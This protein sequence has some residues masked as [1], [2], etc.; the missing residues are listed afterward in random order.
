M[1]TAAH[2]PQV[3]AC[4]RRAARYADDVVPALRRQC[5]CEPSAHVAQSG[6]NQRGTHAGSGPSLARL[7]DRSL[8]HRYGQQAPKRS[9]PSSH[10]SS[11]S[12]ACE[13]A[14][15]SYWPAGR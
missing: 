5:A 13:C 1:A 2:A 11:G 8:P 10:W 14:R 9:Y 6:P 12:R 3:W 7:G 15:G 4:E